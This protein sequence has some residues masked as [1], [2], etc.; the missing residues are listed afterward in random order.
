[1]DTDH[2]EM[3]N[4]MSESEFSEQL[5]PEYFD[6]VV[7]VAPEKDKVFQLTEHLTGKFR[8]YIDFG[9]FSYTENM[10][11][12][13]ETVI[14][15]KSR[16]ILKKALSVD[17][18]PGRKY[19]IQR[20]NTDHFKDINGIYGYSMGNQLLR[21]CGHY[22]KK[23]DTERSR[24]IICKD[25]ISADLCRQRNTK[26]CLRRLNRQRDNRIVFLA[27]PPKKGDAKFDV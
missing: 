6:G 1:M 26:L 5:L 24:V 22:M 4:Q 12:I 15:P 9:N 18:I 2:G 3:L 11:R 21:D 20:Y 17:V 25:I 14:E 19:R 27:N 8:G 7:F 16:E 10:E 23:H 13:V